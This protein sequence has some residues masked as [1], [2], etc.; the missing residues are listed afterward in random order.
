MARQVP[1]DVPSPKKTTGG[2]SLSH[3]ETTHLSLN[4]VKHLMVH[5]NSTFAIHVGSMAMKDLGIF[6]NDTL[7]VDR[8]IEPRHNHVV[9]AVVN[10]EFLVRRIYFKN[11]I[12]QLRPE[13]SRYP[14]IEQKEGLEIV[15]WG[16]VFSCIKQ[17]FKKPDDLFAS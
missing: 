5:P 4:I 6:K 11:G 15:I 9:L 1:S 16:V 8:S 13:N 10:D 17:I 12:M 14:I 3:G 7:L 2:F